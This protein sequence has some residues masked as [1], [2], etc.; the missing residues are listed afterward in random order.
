[1]RLS[2]N[3]D[4][5]FTH[6]FTRKKQTL[7]AALGVT[8]GLAL[9]IFS[10]SLMRGFSVYSRTEMFKIMPHLKVFKEDEVSKPLQN[11]S[12]A[13]QTVLI[14]NPKITTTTKK[15]A[16]PYKL[17]EEIKQEPYITSVAPQ[18]SVS[19]FY[20]NGKAQL[21][22]VG[23]GVNIIEADIMFNIRST[24]LAGDP[25][26]LA[27]NPNAIIIGKG[28]ASKLNVGMGDNLTVSSSLGI[29][30]NMKIVGI[31]STGNKATDESKSYLQI[32]ASQSLLKEGVTYIT[33]IYANITTPDSSIHYAKTLQKIVPY[34]VEDWQTSNAD[35]L[36]GDKV[37][38]IMNTSVT[39]AIMMVAAFGIYNILNMTIMQKMNDIAILK[40]TGFS[41]TDIVRIFILEAMIMGFVGTLIGLGIGAILIYILSK[42]YIGGPVGYF[43]IYYNAE[44]FGIAT[45]FGFLVSLGAGYFPARKAAQVDP[46]DIFRK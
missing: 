1:M 46:V 32:S 19:L 25:Q 45:L 11:S 34:K 31:F 42:V 28:I 40:A 30:K 14:A 20:N 21:K 3:S 6:I 12:E 43:P 37:R 22:G 36:A 23:S 15:I 27:S 9:Y 38:L 35:A 13:S 17:I 18:V 41:G 5:A 16:D 29:V 4:I 8:I 2:V 39:M 24:M 33:D 10:N 26:S 44:V 7:I